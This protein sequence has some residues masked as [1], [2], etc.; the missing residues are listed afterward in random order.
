[1]VYLIIL[2]RKNFR[3]FDFSTAVLTTG[4]GTSGLPINSVYAMIQTLNQLF[5]L[6]K[7]LYGLLM[8]S[9]LKANLQLQGIMEIRKQ[10]L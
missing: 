8:I 6:E 4:H 2:K 1:M 10:T 9:Q 5:C 7:N 3:L